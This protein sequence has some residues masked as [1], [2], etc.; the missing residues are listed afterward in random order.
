MDS[1]LITI[2]QTMDH[3]AWIQQ[4]LTVIQN[5][6]PSPN[7]NPSYKSEKNQ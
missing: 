2:F 4:N 3:L 1:N 6:S 7:K 5:C